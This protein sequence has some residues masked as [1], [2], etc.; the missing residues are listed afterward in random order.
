MDFDL[1]ANSLGAFTCVL[2]VEKLPDGKTGD[3]R[4]VAGNKAY[5]DSIENP[6]Q[7]LN[8][9]NRTFIPN[10]VYTDYIPKDLNFETATIQAAVNKKVIHTYVRPERHGAWLNMVFM[11]LMTD[12]DNLC[13]CTYT[14]EIDLSP[15]TEAMSDVSGEIAAAVLNNCLVLSGNNDFEKAMNEVVKSIRQMC[16]AEMCVIL[17]LNNEEQSCRVL[18]ED[19][20]EDTELNPFGFHIEKGFYKVV[21]TWADTISGSNCLILKD[22]NDMNYLKKK[23][24]A[25]YDSLINEKIFSLVLFP[26]KSGDETIGYIWADNFDPEKSDKIKETLEITT[27]ILSSEISNYLLLD[28]LETLSSRDM[29]TG[30]MNRNTM[31]NFVDRLAQASEKKSHSLGVIFADLNGLKRVNDTEGHIA[32]DRLIKKAADILTEVFDIDQIFRAGGDEFSVILPSTTKEEVADKIQKVRDLSEK[33]GNVSLAIGSCVVSDAKDI[34][35][36]LR[37]ADEDM[38]ADKK[39]YY[40]T[41]PEAERR[42]RDN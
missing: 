19:L 8:M 18:S 32:G 1:I 14:M 30:V 31:N 41:H 35:L 15:N 3:I 11:P 34:R 17:L 26:I 12:H 29:L 13:Y 9:E 20:A 6:I 23:N 33:S 27:F 2:S 25:W 40:A 4:I 10:S 37:K 21:S 39:R 16:S 28:R 24:R 7:E 38:Y 22:E 5:I 42:K 36:A